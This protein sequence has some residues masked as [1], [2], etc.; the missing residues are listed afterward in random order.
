MSHIML[1]G[2]QGSGKGTQARKILEHS[3]AYTLFEMGTELRKFAQ[4]GT[5][6]G[7]ETKRC[8]E[9]GL[10]A[11]T[12]AVV[13]MA[14]A[15]V[16]TNK[17]K[18]ILLDGVIR[19]QEQN[20]ALEPVFGDFIVI[21][22]S[23]DVETAVARLGGRRIDPITSETFPASYKGETN[24]KTGNQLVVRADDTEEAIRSRISWSIAD[25]LPLIDTWEAHGHRVYKIDASQSEE[26][27]FA[28]IERVITK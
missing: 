7:D 10:K 18:K 5:P 12:S 27:I 9:A 20:T 28:E 25:T 4:T 15:Y 19:S 2:I 8:I 3:D 23:L 24:P 14:E 1:I 21:Y 11:P 22:L 17:D 16:A 13:A 26:E 6:E